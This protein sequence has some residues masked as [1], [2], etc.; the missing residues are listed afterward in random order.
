IEERPL[1]EEHRHLPADRDEAVLVE[2]PECRPFHLD[3][4][5]IRAQ[6]AVHVLQGHALA[7]AA[8]AEEDERLARQHVEREPAQDGLVAEALLDGTAADERR[9][10]HEARKSLV[11]KKSAT[12]TVMEAATTVAVVARPTPSAPP[13]TRSPFQQAM[14]PMK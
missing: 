7:G 3:L 11:R 4:A 14:M 8:A 13:V 12:N 6:E 9:V 1:L 5:T 10:A 2:R